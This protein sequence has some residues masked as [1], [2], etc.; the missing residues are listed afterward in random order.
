MIKLGQLVALLAFVVTANLPSSAHAIEPALIEVSRVNFC[1]ASSEPYVKDAVIDCS[2]ETVELPHSWTPV[3]DGHPSE[4]IGLKFH[5]L[6]PA[7]MA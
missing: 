2:L 4:F 1:E 3:R 6:S 5:G 7:R